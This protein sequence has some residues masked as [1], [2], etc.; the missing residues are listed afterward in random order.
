VPHTHQPKVT[1]PQKENLDKLLQESAKN[2][3]SAI[4]E[5]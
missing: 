1:S 3:K 2:L 4:T 5:E